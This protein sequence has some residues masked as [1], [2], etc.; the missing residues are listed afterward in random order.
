[1]LTFL[2]KFASFCMILTKTISVLPPSGEKVPLQF[3]SID[4][5]LPPSVTQQ[6][7]LVASKEPTIPDWYPALS[8]CDW[9]A[10]RSDPL[11]LQR[12][13]RPP[14]G[15][16]AC[17]RKIS[18]RKTFPDLLFLGLD[19]KLNIAT[20]SNRERLRASAFWPQPWHLATLLHLTTPLCFLG[21]S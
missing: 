9:S 15:S 11:C 5:K 8:M 6:R 16:W 2:C 20:N 4:L 18:N 10:T 1:M 12:W 13:G 17:C 7:P 19:K 21:E 14:H 3:D